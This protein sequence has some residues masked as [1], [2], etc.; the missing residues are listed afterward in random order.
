MDAITLHTLWVM[1][2]GIEKTNC[3][4]NLQLPIL[5]ALPLDQYQM[6]HSLH[7]FGNPLFRRILGKMNQ[8][9]ISIYEDLGDT[10]LTIYSDVHL[11]FEIV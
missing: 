7:T 2:E 8:I 9:K 1:C 4:S 11:R 6:E 5:R 10:P 3:G